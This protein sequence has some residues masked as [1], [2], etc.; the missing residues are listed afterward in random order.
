MT[1]GDN[2]TTYAGS[3]LRRSSV[4][5]GDGSFV[6][7]GCFFDNAGPIII[8]HRC[9]I[10]MRAM[11]CTSNHEV[12]GPEQR[13]GAS[14][15]TAVTIQDGRWIGTCAV[16]LPGVTIATGCIVA[17]GAVVSRDTEPH[18]LYAGVQRSQSETLTSEVRVDTDPTLARARL[19]PGQ[20]LINGRVGTLPSLN[21]I[22]RKMD[23]LARC[24]RS[25]ADHETRA[26]GGVP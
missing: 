9:L 6:N 23:V 14:S 17:A 21:A 11:L 16:V 12:G 10:G 20:R 24:A 8:G 22:R 1:L 2:T 19:C 25:D 7:A 3:F 15:G 5:V 13:G 4:T 26:G 18:G